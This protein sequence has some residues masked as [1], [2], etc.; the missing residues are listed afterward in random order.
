M[1]SRAVSNPFEGAFCGRNVFVT[2]HTGFKGAWLCEWLLQMGATV[3]GYALAPTEPALFEQLGLATRLTGHHLGDVRDS[4]MLREV[5]LESRP[6]FVFHL[7]AQA[8]V[9]ESYRQPLDTH[10]TNILGTVHLLEA[11]RELAIPCS[12][13]VVTSDKCYE[14]REWIHGYRESDRLGGH[15]PYSASKAAAELMVASYRHSFFESHAVR[16]ATARA[17]NVIGG[18]DWALDRIIPDCVRALQA[19]QSIGIRNP[20]SVRPWQHVLEPLSGYLWLAARMASAVPKD[21]SLLASAFNFG[22]DYRS[23]RTVGELVEE[24]LTYWP[25]RWQDQSDPNAVHEAGLLQLDIDKAHALLK[26]SPV[27]SFSETIQKTAHWYRQSFEDPS[28]DARALTRAQIEAYCAAAQAQ[29][30]PWAR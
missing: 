5:L 29:G 23:N 15:D 7:A 18:G 27:W 16:L 11:L 20:S 9:R 3:S 21:A 13:V 2:G 30:L 24:L 1:Q 17:G 4:G 22:P 8:L 25:G 26:W 6:N 10:A 12:V 28:F 14:N 19:G